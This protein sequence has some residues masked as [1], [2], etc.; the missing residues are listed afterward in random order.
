MDGTNMDQHLIP[1]PL[2]RTG[3]IEILESL[4]LGPISRWPLNQGNLARIA[5]PLLHSS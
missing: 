4:A 2:T 3:N 5:S 1:S